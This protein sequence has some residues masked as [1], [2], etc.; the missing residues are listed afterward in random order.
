MEE[1]DPTIEDSYMKQIQV[2]GLNVLMD[3][4]DTAGQEEF[5][6]M[7]CQW[8][9]EYDVVFLC[10]SISNKQSWNEVKVLRE[11]EL[12]ANE[13]ETHVAILVGTKCD[14]RGQ[15]NNDK[16]VDQEVVIEQ[17]R[18]WNMPYVETSAKDRKNIDFLFDLVVYE[19]WYQSQ[20]PFIPT[21]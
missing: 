4:L 7:R 2:N 10:F 18:E 20:I 1:Y 11:K 8:I 17:A 6:S 12:R 15:I 19:L 21:F 13:G 16:L 3:V 5:L 14:L 9:R